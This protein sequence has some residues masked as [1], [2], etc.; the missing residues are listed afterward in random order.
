[1]KDLYDKNIKSLMKEIE[2]DTRK[3]RDLPCLWIG[4][5]NIVKM[6]ILAK[7]IYR[8]NAIPNKITKQFF[9]DLK[10]TIFNYIWKS[11]KLRIAKTI[12][13]SKETSGSITI[14][15]F[16]LYYRATIRKKQLGF[17]IKNRHVDEWNR[18]QDPDMF[19]H[20]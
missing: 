1:M 8:F 15:D 17:G 9:T 13:Y 12:L 11:K 3:W 4:R 6:A 10:R 19:K 20:L 14:P 2:E 7:T 16:K 5:I 18:I